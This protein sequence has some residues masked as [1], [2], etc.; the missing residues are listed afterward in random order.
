MGARASG[1]RQELCL[2][3]LL[4]FPQLLEEFLVDF[5][6]LAQVLLE[7]LL[8]FEDFLVHVDLFADVRVPEV[9]EA[10]EAVFGR[11]VGCRQAGFSGG[12]ACG[13]FRR[14][15]FGFGL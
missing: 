13:F 15:G 4:D 8:A 11:A 12:L 9:E 7:G 3:R 14:A 5:L 6:R 1:I 2:E 10:V